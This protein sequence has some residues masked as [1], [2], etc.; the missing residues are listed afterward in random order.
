MF[1]ALVLNKEPSFSAKV[2]ELNI[3]SLP[4]TDTEVDVEYS[5]LTLNGRRATFLFI[6]VGV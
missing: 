1:K 5:T 2:E 4:H 3:E 6:M